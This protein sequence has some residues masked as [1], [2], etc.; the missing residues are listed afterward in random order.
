M[1]WW[2]CWRAC[3]AVSPCGRE[4]VGRLMPSS[5]AT[6]AALR[7]VPQWS[8]KWPSRIAPGMAVTTS[9]AVLTVPR[10]GRLRL[11]AASCPMLTAWSRMSARPRTG[12]MLEVCNARKV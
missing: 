11:L 4:A 10:V 3:L 7:P 1:R 9:R 5:R 2:A 8:R 6:R 12:K